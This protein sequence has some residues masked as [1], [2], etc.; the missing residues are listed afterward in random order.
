MFIDITIYREKQFIHITNLI[1]EIKS[2]KAMEKE[3]VTSNSRKT[4]AFKNKW[5]IKNDI[6]SIPR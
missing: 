2:A 4:I 6:I 1:A 3:I 5:H